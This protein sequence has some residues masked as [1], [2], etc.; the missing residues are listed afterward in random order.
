MMTSKDVDFVW[1]QSMTYSLRHFLEAFASRLPVVVRVTQ[2]YYFEK[3]EMEFGA[4][5]VGGV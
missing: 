5:E 1:S 2:G 3:E 4:D